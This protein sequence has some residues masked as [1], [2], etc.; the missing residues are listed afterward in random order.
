MGTESSVGK[1]R[2]QERAQ[3]TGTNWMEHAEYVLDREERDSVE[4]ECWVQKGQG[5]VCG[6]TVY[7]AVD[8]TSRE[9]QVVFHAVSRSGAPVRYFG[10][11][12]GEMGG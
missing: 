11:G 1:G 9:A 12:S 2:G 10:G 5:F 8:K 7:W 3:Q 6:P 4:L